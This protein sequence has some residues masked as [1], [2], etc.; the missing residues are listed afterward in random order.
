[1]FFF[2]FSSRR[3]HTRF[4]CDWSSDVCSSDLRALPQLVVQVRRY[5]RWFPAADR[6]PR[7]G[8]PGARDTGLPDRA[9]FDRLD[10]LAR[11]ERGALLRPHRHH[12]PALALRLDQQLPLPRVV[13][14][15]LLDIAIV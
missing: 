6:A 12:P 13:R 2:F 10:D 15:R 11:T 9:F 5:G 4:D 7:V 3:R 8:V 1:M 14:P